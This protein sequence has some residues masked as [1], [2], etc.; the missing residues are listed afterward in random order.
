MTGAATGAS[1]AASR[2]A[3]HDRHAMASASSVATRAGLCPP[4]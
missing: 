1:D 2:L 4:G 3:A